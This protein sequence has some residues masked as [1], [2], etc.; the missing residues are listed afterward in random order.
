MEAYFYV[1]FAHIIGAAIIFGTGVGLAFFMWTS[2]RAENL[3]ERL[4]V[5][6]WA[7]KAEFIFTLPTILIQPA[8]GFFMVVL[9]DFEPTEDWLI[10][11]TA[12]SRLSCSVG[13]L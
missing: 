9:L 2:Y 4:F 13:Y 1:K 7:V 11:P 10:W 5:A 12:F 6:R 3:T 8:T